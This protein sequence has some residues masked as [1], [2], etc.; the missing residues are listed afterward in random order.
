MKKL[1]ALFSSIALLASCQQAPKGPTQAEFDALAQE[2]DSLTTHIVELQDLIGSVTAC[3]DSI[4]AQEN[5]LFVNNEDGTKATKR[6]IIDR[7]QN[8]KD[9]LARQSEQLARL[10]NQVKSD[11]ASIR[12]L[13]TIIGRLRQDIH[14]KEV[15]IAELENDL[16][17]R[18]KD[19]AQ[20]EKTL[21]KSEENT[22][23]MTKARDA[24]L[25]VANFQKDVINTA[26]FVVGSKSMLRDLGIVKGVFKQKADYANLDNSKFS[27]VDIREFRELNIN[28]KKAKLIT[29]KPANSYLLIENPDETT[30]LRITDPDAFWEG[31]PYLIIQTK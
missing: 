4:D 24:L 20:L 25:E 6:Q 11:K 9:L 12:D 1:F 19:I 14:D 5:L 21:A 29:E 3:F 22:A 23:T 16:N 7:I 27:K 30:T 17:N 31:S 26:Y 2:K 8:Y 18:N 13:R 28:S 15:R 10:E